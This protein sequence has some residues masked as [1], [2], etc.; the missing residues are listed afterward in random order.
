MR[1]ARLWLTAFRVLR[2]LGLMHD[3]RRDYWL[4]LRDLARRGLDDTLGLLACVKEGCWRWEFAVADETE[5]P[6]YD[7][8]MDPQDRWEGQK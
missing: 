5:D 7:G 1:R 2:P 3:W 8:W 4:N 6:G